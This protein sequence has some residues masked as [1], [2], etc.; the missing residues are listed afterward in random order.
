M[1]QA[2]LNFMASDES[3]NETL[4]ITDGRRR[5]SQASRDR[6][7]AAMLALVEEG[8]IT[9]SAEDVAAR[10]DVGLRSVFR[11]FKDMES[12][13][14]EM[15]LRVAR[16]Y[17]A[18]L[19]PFSGETWREQLAEATERRLTV[20]ERLLPFKRAADAHRHESPAIQASHAATQQMLRHRLRS[21][22]PTALADDPLV[23]ETLDLWLSLEAWLRLRVEQQLPAEAA[24][25]LVQAQVA[26]LV[27]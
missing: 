15:A 16:G 22:L 27:D 6:I 24:V 3:V 4:P 7:V 26:R 11:H 19:A 14:A 23:F 17:L 8:A 1:P 2:T 10:A 18:A 9:P 21:V 20:Y 5:R 25:A 12:L 13:Y